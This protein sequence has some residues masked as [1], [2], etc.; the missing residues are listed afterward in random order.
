MLYRTRPHGTLCTGTSVE[1]SAILRALSKKYRH[2][3][4]FMYVIHTQGCAI[5]SSKM[6]IE[7][8]SLEAT[9]QK[10]QF[11]AI[12]RAFESDPSLTKM[13]RLD[14]EQPYSYL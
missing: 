8:F 13:T 12:K 5:M 9:Q 10:A 2:Y 1:F 7:A 4:Y 14:A 11:E 6:S 3:L